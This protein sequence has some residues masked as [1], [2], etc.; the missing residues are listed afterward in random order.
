MSIFFNGKFYLIVIDNLGWLT[1]CR[2]NCNHKI[3]IIIMI[4]NGGN[5]MKWY[6][7]FLYFSS[8]F[9]PF[10]SSGNDSDVLGYSYP[11]FADF[12]DLDLLDFLS[13]F[14][15]LCLFFLW[16]FISFESSP[17]PGNWSMMLLNWSRNSCLPLPLY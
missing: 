1:F 14:E 3:Y 7:L 2:E 8:C 4:K 15:L 13:F 6:L 5:K 17:I 9:R 11:Y 16:F 12:C 10:K